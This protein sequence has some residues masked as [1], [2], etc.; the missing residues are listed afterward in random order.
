M[1]E[2]QKSVKEQSLISLL[3]SVLESSEHAAAISGIMEKLKLSKSCVIESFLRYNMNVHDHG[4]EIYHSVAIRLV[5][6]IHNLIE[7]SWHIERQQTVNDFINMISPSYVLD[8]GFGVPSLYVKNLLAKK[9]FRLTLCDFS[10]SAIKF[11]G[12]L[13]ACWGKYWKDCVELKQEDLIVIPFKVDLGDYDFFIFQD[14]IEH[15][16]EPAKHLSSYIINSTAQSHFLLSLPIG[17]ITPEH[18]IEW[19]SVEDAVDWLSDC[20]LKII[21]SKIIQTNPQVDLFAD[22]HQFNYSDFYA[23]CSK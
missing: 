12:V 7:G 11:A 14:S 21:K 17:P 1:I 6:H 20:G 15:V 2:L 23:L 9:N 4:N 18:S 10:V 5:L 8:L 3:S 19:A 22:V 13:L 16:K